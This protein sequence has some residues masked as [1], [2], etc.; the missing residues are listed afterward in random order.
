MWT[1]RHDILETYLKSET[2][3]RLYAI[4]LSLIMITCATASYA[5]LM[6]HVDTQHTG[7]TW[8]Y[9][10]QNDEPIGSSNYN[11]EYT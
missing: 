5:D 9:T 7:S 6:T 3:M 2:N 4:L 8:T 1:V 11:V 10:V